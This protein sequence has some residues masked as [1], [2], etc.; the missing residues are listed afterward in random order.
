MIKNIKPQE[1]LT[2]RQSGT[3]ITLLDVRDD[4]ETEIAPV[5]SPIVHIPMSQVP[6]R[7]SE[8]D[9]ALETV[10]ICRSGA[11]SMEVARF[12]EHAGFS[13]VSNMTGGILAWGRDVD[14]TI[15]PY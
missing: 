14:P 4:W 9:P 6:D 11:R 13:A 12:L 2:L 8:L 1:F 3:P 7:L 10:V 5:P 15:K